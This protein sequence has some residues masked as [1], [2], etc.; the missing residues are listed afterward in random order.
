MRKTEKKII[1]GVTILGA[2]GLIAYQQGVYTDQKIMAVTGLAFLGGGLHI[3]VKKYSIHK[4]LNTDFYGGSNSHWTV[5]EAL[6]EVK[7][8]SRRNYSSRNQVHMDWSNAAVWQTEETGRDDEERVFYAF[9]TV[10]GEKGRGTMVY[11]DAT[12]KR[13]PID[14]MP[15]RFKSQLRE[16][17]R[18]CNTVQ[19]LRK[20]NAIKGFEVDGR[21]NRRVPYINPGM[22]MDSNIQN[23]DG[24]PE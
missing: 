16:P 5:D 23:T 19:R 18:Y 1:Y 21:R 13:A 11:V 24:N 17:F 14:H 15:V 3:A 10:H 6:E 7:K 12:K 4:W 22:P 20:E 2:A 8:W 9:Y